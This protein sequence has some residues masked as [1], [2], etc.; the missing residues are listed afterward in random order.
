MAGKTWQERQADIDKL[1]GDLAY[2]EACAMFDD[3]TRRSLAKMGESLNLTA[4]PLV[5]FLVLMG[6]CY[7]TSLDTKTLNVIRAV[8]GGDVNLEGPGYDLPF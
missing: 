5:S 2:R 3:D 4:A 1:Q 7:L 6:A 8:T